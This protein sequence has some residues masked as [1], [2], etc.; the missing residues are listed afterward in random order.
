MSD[1]LK[2]KSFLNVYD[3]IIIRRP[4]SGLAP[5]TNASSKFQ[6]VYVL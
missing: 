4:L 6:H 5:L 1:F 2:L 3:I